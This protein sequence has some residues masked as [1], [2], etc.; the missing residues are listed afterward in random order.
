[1]GLGPKL[2]GLLT[3]N[4]PVGAVVMTMLV[5]WYVSLD[6]RR[7]SIVARLG[8]CLGS[9]RTIAVPHAEQAVASRYPAMLV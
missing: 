6:E 9:L 5:M 3:K 8:G 7:A 1:M 4:E 2:S